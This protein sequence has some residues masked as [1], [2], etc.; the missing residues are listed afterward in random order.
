MDDIS[1]RKIKKLYWTFLGETLLFAFSII[2]YL[3]LF[4]WTMYI[5]FVLLSLL[6]GTFSLSKILE[7]ITLK[8]VYKNNTTEFTVPRLFQKNNKSIN[9][10]NTK[11]KIIW[12]LNTVPFI[13]LSLFFVI[14]DVVLFCL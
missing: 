4:N 9:P 3:L 5:L 8:K 6:F 1:L 2:I 13:F 10:N 12:F 11:G 7:Y 14:F